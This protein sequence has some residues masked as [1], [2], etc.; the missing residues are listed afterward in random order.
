MGAKFVKDLAVITLQPAGSE[1]HSAKKGY[2][3]KLSSGK[4]A[5]NDSATVPA[6]GVILDGEANGGVDGIG[7]L[8][9]NLGTVKLKA[10]G[11][12]TFGARLMQKN[13]GTV[14]VENTAVARVV[15]A[16][17]LEAAA[18]TELFEAMVIAPEKTTAAVATADA[19]D[20]ASAVALA[21]A[22]KAAFNAELATE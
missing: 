18:D 17:A 2:L 13:D 6:F 22:L 8:G 9:G 11:A 10:G 19:T 15:M 20:L 16:I 4:A 1:D 5:L 3:V 21:N 7:V 12:I 14:V